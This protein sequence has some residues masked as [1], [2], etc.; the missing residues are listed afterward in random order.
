FLMGCKM[1]MSPIK[2]HIGVGE[3][4]YVVFEADG[5][6]GQ[7]DLYAGSASGGPVYR[8]T[9]S[10]AHES[11]P[12]L[13]PDGAMLA[14][15]RGGTREDSVSFRVWIM[16]LLSGAERE[17][18][19]LADSAFPRQL[20]WAPDGRTLFIRTTRGDFFT[21]APP[22]KPGIKPVVLESSAAADSALE[23]R[24]GD[25]RR[26]KVTTCP[27]GRGLCV[28]ADSGGSQPLTAEGRDAFRWGD[29]SVGF[30]IGDVVSVRPLGGGVTREI[31]WAEMPAHPRQATQFPG[32][33]ERQPSE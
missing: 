8:I 18:P 4:S 21:P 17:L 5:E 9:Y 16:N 31:R 15:I 29:D 28:P 14:F 19:S 2:N 3:E 20:G 12:A 33:P 24:L 32:V 27:D 11:S 7:G 30:W 26:A 10:R 1:S 22:S 25:D 6:A 23:V 13:S